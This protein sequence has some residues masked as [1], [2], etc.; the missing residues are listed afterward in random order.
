M[1]ELEDFRLM[2]NSHAALP[3]LTVAYGAPTSNIAIDL[4][5]YTNQSAPTA[6]W[7]LETA[8][9]LEALGRRRPGWDS[10]GGLPLKPGAKSL[11]LHILRWLGTEE[12]PVP[13]VVLCSAGTV[14]LEWKSKGKEL[15]VE[16]LDNNTFEYMKVLP[17]GETEEGEDAIDLS[18]RIHALSRWLR[19]S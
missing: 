3:A 2:H 6:E 13:A 16:L 15:E 18:G 17:G 19:Q 11:T 8:K 14:Q 9:K 7:V 4:S 12:L 5:G 10:Y 1:N